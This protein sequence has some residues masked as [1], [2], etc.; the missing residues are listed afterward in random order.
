MRYSKK[1]NIFQAF[2]AKNMNEGLTYFT[3]IKE[4]KHLIQGDFFI[5]CSITL[6][7]PKKAYS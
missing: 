6:Q 1:L 2:F 7:A 5:L 3:L 4:G